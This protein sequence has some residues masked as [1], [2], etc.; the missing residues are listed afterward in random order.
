MPPACSSRIYKDRLAGHIQLTTDWHRAYLAAVGEGFDWVIDYAMLVKQYGLAPQGNPER[1]YSPAERIGAVKNGV[2]G[3]TDQKHISMPDAERSKLTLRMG[4]R[5]FTRPAAPLSKK[6][7]N[8]A[9]TVA[10][11]MMRYNFARTHKTLRITP[12]MTAGV[13]DH[14]WSLEEIAAL[15]Q[16]TV[17]IRP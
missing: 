17:I 2:S 14:V 5:R 6:V 7:K 3:Q 1:R 9:H 12:A 11:H 8:Q 15:G 13:T 4:C 16:Q 10:L